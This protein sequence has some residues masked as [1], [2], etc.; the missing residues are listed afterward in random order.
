LIAWTSQLEPCL[1]GI[2]AIARG[3]DPIQRI[4]ANCGIGALS[5]TAVVASV[6]DAT[7]FRNA[8]RFCAW[9][10]LA[11]RQFPTG[12]KPHLGRITKRGDVYLRTLLVH[13][14]RSAL[15]M[16]SKRTDRLAT[17]A[18]ALVARRGYK[19]AIVALAVKNA[20]FV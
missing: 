18:K 1:V 4:M 6:G 7:L 14:T 19:K 3:S 15:N 16:L 8:R 12:G 13:G 20:R 9:L 11:A 2:E 5:A 10:G 17:G